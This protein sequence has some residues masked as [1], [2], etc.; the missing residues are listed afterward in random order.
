MLTHESRQ[1]AGAESAGDALQEFQLGAVTATC[2]LF[3]V[4]KARQHACLGCWHA[5]ARLANCNAQ[6]HAN[7]AQIAV[8]C[9]R[10]VGVHG[11][12]LGT[13]WGHWGASG[14]VGDPVRV[15]GSCCAHWALQRR[16][17]S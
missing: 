17:E 11:D 1:D 16:Q 14:D 7:H 15:L 9:T 6:L 12:V 3:E 2:R 5:A 10:Y 13:S 8:Y 4:A